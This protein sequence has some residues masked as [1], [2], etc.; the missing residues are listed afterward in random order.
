VSKYEA[1]LNEAKAMIALHLRGNKPD[2]AI[3]E[4]AHILVSN[5]LSY[6]WRPPVDPNE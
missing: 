1:A 3:N 2:M 4:L 5:L 6:G